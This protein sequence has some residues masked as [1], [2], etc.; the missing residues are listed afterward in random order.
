MDNGIYDP[1]SLR[2]ELAN[3][4]RQNFLA[5]NPVTA[6][7]CVQGRSMLIGLRMYVEMVQ[8]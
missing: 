1:G 8:S 4:V 7:F 2:E 5:Y 3:L 6:E